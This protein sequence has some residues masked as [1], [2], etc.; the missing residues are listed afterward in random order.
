[1]FDFFSNHSKVLRASSLLN[2]SYFEVARLTLTIF[3]QKDD[4]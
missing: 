1:M 3:R 2:G 4:F